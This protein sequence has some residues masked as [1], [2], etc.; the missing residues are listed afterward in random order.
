MSTRT[1]AAG[2]VNHSPTVRDDN[3]VP[4]SVP[5]PGLLSSL[6]ASENGL[7]TA[8]AERRLARHGANALGADIHG[9]VIRLVLRQ[10]ASPIVLLLIGAALLSVLLHD[11]TD[12]AI[13]LV[14]VAIS[15]MLG[16][17]QEYHAASIVATLLST[18]ELKATVVRDGG[19]TQVPS[20]PSCPATSSACRP[21]RHSGGL[22]RLA[23]PISSSRGPLTGEPFPIEKSEGNAAARRWAGAPTCYS[24]VRTRSAAPRAPWCADGSRDGVWTDLRRV[25][26]S[27]RE[28]SSSGPAPLRVPWSR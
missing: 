2:V 16:F 11:T 5:L 4:W 10:F 18:V 21:G 24:R 6:D 17:W 28:A 23:S 13:I 9:R 1:F 19:E 3:G 15:G 26:R 22:P 7:T 8:E 12:G 14:I 20:A 25:R 27:R